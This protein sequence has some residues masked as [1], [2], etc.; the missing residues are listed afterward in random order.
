MQLEGVAAA[1]TVK[2]SP[3][4]LL[5]NSPGRVQLIQTTDKKPAQKGSGLPKVIQPVNGKGLKLNLERSVGPTLY[6]NAKRELE[7]EGKA[8][9]KR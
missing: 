1:N 4:A 5:Y 9:G 8:S 2:P 6:R 3:G 7:E